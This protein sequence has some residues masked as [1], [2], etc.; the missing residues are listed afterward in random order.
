ML[1]QLPADDNLALAD[2][3]K[4]LAHPTRLQIVDLLMQGMHCN[5]EL[6]AQLGL[7]PNLLSYHLRLLEA[8]GLVASARDEH[9]ARWI[10]Y[11]VRQPVLVALR[12]AV[13][14]LLD[15]ARIMPRRPDCGPRACGP[16]ACGP[17]PCGPRACGPP[18]DGG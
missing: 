12:Q 7:A 15:P 2:A 4:A 9:D 5:C 18:S 14:T 13:S 16:R 17:R 1:K 10:Y 6:A 8:A 11:T 3:L